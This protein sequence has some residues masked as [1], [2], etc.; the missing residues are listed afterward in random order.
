MSAF[1]KIKGFFLR[2][3]EWMS[4]FWSNFVATILGIVLTFGVT[5][6]LERREE[7]AKAKVL[8]E[9]SFK[10]IERRIS[11]LEDVTETLKYQD[12]LLLICQN[13]LPNNLDS[14]PSQVFKNLID[15]MGVSW[16]LFESK[17]VEIGFKQNFNSQKM[18]GS[19]ADVLGEMFEALNYAEN[20]NVAIN[21]EK[22]KIEQKSFKYW[23]NGRRTMTREEC[24]EMLMQPETIY[25]LTNISTQT[26]S[27]VR[28]LSYLKVYDQNAHELWDQKITFEQFDARIEECENNLF[29]Q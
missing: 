1:S 28:V 11:D 17:S 23:R 5:M 24:L 2:H 18:L 3:K 13:H 6:W 27:L 8:V 26:H 16:S 20:L 21:Q 7:Q 29:G 25:I 9:R 22:A 15:I 19:F 4:S 14:V 12:S 10:N